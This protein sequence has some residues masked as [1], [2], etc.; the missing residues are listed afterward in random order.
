MPGR[1]NLIKLSHICRAVLQKSSPVA[2]LPNL[3]ALEVDSAD[4]QVLRH[5]QELLAALLAFSWLD[6][7]EGGGRQLSY[8]YLRA[9][10]SSELSELEQLFV[11]EEDVRLLAV[12]VCNVSAVE[13]DVF[14]PEI[15]TLLDS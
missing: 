10:L 4:L 14:D 15:A 1:H 13:G 3:A 6:R 5:E 11:E 9:N 2:N 8:S 7:Q 12:R